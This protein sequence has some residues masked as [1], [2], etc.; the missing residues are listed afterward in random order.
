MCMPLCFNFDTIAMMLY[1]LIGLVLSL[2]SSGVGFGLSFAMV[3]RY[4]D[5]VGGRLYWFDQWSS[6]WRWVGVRIFRS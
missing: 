6:E 1:Q 3:W 4:F 2:A 5:K